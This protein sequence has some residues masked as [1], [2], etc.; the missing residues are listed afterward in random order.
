MA[1]TYLPAAAQKLLVSMGYLTP[2]QATME[3]SRV[4]ETAR[5]GT[6][7]IVYGAVEMASQEAQ[8]KTFQSEFQAAID[9][10]D[11]NNLAEEVWQVRE[12]VL[13]SSW[14]ASKEDQATL[15]SLLNADI[16]TGLPLEP[17]ANNVP[18]TVDATV[19]AQRKATLQTQL[20]SA[21]ALYN[22]L[23][24]LTGVGKSTVDWPT[25]APVEA[26]MGDWLKMQG[27]SD[28]DL[29]SDSYWLTKSVDDSVIKMSDIDK[30]WTFPSFD[31][32]ADQVFQLTQNSDSP[33]A[34]WNVSTKSFYALSGT[35]E[36]KDIT[37][38]EFATGTG[39]DANGTE[40]HYVV[41]DNGDVGTYAYPYTL[42]P[43]DVGDKPMWLAIHK[44]TTPKVLDILMENVG[45][46]YDVVGASSNSATNIRLW[47]DGTS[48]YELG[49]KAPDS[50]FKL[51][52]SKYA[53]FQAD[54]N[55]GVAAADPLTAFL[56]HGLQTYT[57]T[58]TVMTSVDG[59]RHAAWDTFFKAKMAA[60]DKSN[61][62]LSTTTSIES[63]RITEALQSYN[64][65]AL[66]LSNALKELFDIMKLFIKD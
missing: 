48:I 31:T 59:D 20:D 7:P 9:Q 27:I 30:T 17:P 39:L 13:S 47:S 63:P 6:T 32:G 65:A 49:F 1:L 14:P 37:N 11:I 36:T 54:L 50:Q 57:D 12:K 62:A 58:K 21:N 35:T 23:A 66:F 44:D 29:S 4:L 24:A 19:L 5:K 61:S 25:S 60:L 51:S 22:K 52:S 8:L 28:S 43:Y 18:D 26:A 2:Q 3:Y 56:G 16:A 41:P 53:D 64:T 46:D 34:V 42:Y 33:K 15:L 40:R 38:A 10:M 55:A 45:T